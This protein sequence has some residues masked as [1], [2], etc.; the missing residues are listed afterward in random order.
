MATS[1]I[2]NYRYAIRIAFKC[3]ANERECTFFNL[4]IP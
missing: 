4:R 3:S 2:I 1:V